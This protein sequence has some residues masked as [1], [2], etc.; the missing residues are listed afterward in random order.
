MNKIKGLIGG[1]TSS[2]GGNVVSTERRRLTV[3][4]AGVE[5]SSS[6][7]ASASKSQPETQ[8]GLIQFLKQNGTL[9]CAPSAQKQG[10]GHRRGSF[11]VGSVTCDA[12]DSF[13]DKNVIT[14]G[15]EIVNHETLR[16]MGVGIRCK[17]GFKPEAPN[18]DSFSFIHMEGEFDLYGVFDGHGVFGHDV[19]NFVREFLPKLFISD[20]NRE[21]GNIKQ[22]MIDSFKKIQQMIEATTQIDAR[23]SGTTCTIAYRV[24]GSNEL[25]VAHCGDSRAVI[26]YE[27]KG[28]PFGVELTADHKPNLPAERKRIEAA[29]GCVI[30]DGFYN[31]RVFKRGTV[32]PGLNMSRAMGDTIGHREA[33]IVETPDYKVVKLSGSHDYVAFALCSDGVWEFID[34][35]ECARIV[36]R[37]KVD[38]KLDP[39][40][41]AEDLAKQS[42]NRWMEDTGGEI[43]DDITVVIKVMEGK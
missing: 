5:A 13:E 15:E 19:S 32:Y 26:L 14:E 10:G 31:H 25:H 3:T 27:Q 33:G 23:T 42:W 34:S 18:Q 4:Q 24:H 28:K 12:Q 37:H 21:N 39:M 22:A 29:G 9:S 17:K 7:N 20:P 11:A 1:S 43:S 8:R 6:K 38:G 2:S 30:F 16:K 35:N 36:C 40:A 41:A